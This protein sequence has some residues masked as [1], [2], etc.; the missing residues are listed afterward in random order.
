MVEFLQGF[1]CSNVVTVNGEGTLKFAPGR[2]IGSVVLLL[3]GAAVPTIL[4]V[5]DIKNCAHG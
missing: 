3:L 4:G 5:R 2:L 1:A